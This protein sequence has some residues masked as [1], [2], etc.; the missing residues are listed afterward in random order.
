MNMDIRT[1][2]YITG[3]S[4]YNYLSESMKFR[5][6][7]L[8]LIFSTFQEIC[9]IVWKKQ[10]ANHWYEQGTS[11][12]LFYCDRHFQCYIIYYFCP[13]HQ[14]LKLWVTIGFNQNVR[15][16]EVTLKESSK[17]MIL[18]NTSFSVIIENEPIRATLGIP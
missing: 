3:G 15:K 11:P 7:C 1:W 10:R 18:C 8:G 9:V 4:S 6:F 5:H 14:G 16:D 12:S 17:L 13:C 2:S